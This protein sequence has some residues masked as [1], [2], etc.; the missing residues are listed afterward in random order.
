MGDYNTASG[1]PQRR[2]S[3]PVISEFANSQKLF[4]RLLPP[5]ALRP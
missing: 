4:S 5:D 3:E 2:L 1:W